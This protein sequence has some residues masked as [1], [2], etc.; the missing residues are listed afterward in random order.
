[1]KNA[2]N[3]ISKHVVAEWVADVYSNY[4]YGGEYVVRFDDGVNWYSANGVAWHDD[5]GNAVLAPKHAVG[6]DFIG[7]RLDSTFML[8][9]A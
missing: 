4:E 7:G 1:M 5:Q 2:K 3:T 9:V 8:F 6:I